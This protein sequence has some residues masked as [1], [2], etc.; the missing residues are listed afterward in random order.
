MTSGSAKYKMLEAVSYF[1][2]NKNRKLNFNSRDIEKIRK[3]NAIASSK[4]NKGNQHYLNRAPAS[5]DLKK[6]R[7]SNASKSM[8]INNGKEEKFSQD[9]ASLVNNRGYNYGRLPFNQTW[10]KK[11]SQHAHL[12]STPAANMKK[13]IALKGK[14]KSAEH[15]KKLKESKEKILPIQCIH[16]NKL[17]DPPNY[18]KWHGENC[19]EIKP[20]NVVCCEHCGVNSSY[21][22]YRRWHGAKCRSIKSS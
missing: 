21:A 8:W 6:L 4:R 14:P 10:I 1:S 2:N 15:I 20:R 13:S 17:V 18:S 11:I 16:C 7:S 9:H 5:T 12:M 3:S 19:K 22:N